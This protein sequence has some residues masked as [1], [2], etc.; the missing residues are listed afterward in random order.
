MES[1]H[2]VLHETTNGTDESSVITQEKSLRS[3]ERAL[4]SGWLDKNVFYDDF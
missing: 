1:K 3:A 4:N 2:I